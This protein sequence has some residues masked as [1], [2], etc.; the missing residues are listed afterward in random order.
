MDRKE[1]RELAFKV[2]NGEVKGVKL[3]V[4]YPFL[5]HETLE[6][7]VDHF[8]EK[9]EG[10]KLMSLLPFVSQETVN[11]IYES[12]KSGKVTN[13]K[14]NYLLPFLGKAQI[15]ELFDDLVKQAHEAAEAKGDDVDDEDEVD[16]DDE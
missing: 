15:K 9:G 5:D 13:I 16:L 14:E 2:L 10:K 1:I 8:V 12:V 7:I 11:K 6:E 4:L 3:V